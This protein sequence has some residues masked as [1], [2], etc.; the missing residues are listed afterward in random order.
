VGL[1]GPETSDGHDEGRVGGSKDNSD[2]RKNGR[3]KGKALLLEFQHDALRPGPRALPNEQEDVFTTS[4]NLEN[5]QLVKGPGM[6]GGDDERVW[7]E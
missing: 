7:R 6:A 5:A 1:L 3:E 2:E 4:H